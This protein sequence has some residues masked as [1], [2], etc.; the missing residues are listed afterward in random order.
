MRMRASH[1]NRSLDISELTKKIVEQQF[2]ALDMY[3]CYYINMT[4]G[5]SP[6]T[7]TNCYRNLLLF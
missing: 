2:Y 5:N 7:F 6:R 1:L 3:K 4:G